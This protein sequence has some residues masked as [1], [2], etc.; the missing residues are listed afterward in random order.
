MTI[1]A[2]AAAA[3]LLSVTGCSGSGP[4][5]AAA[6]VDSPARTPVTRPDRALS[7][8]EERRYNLNEELQPVHLSNCEFERIGDS[9]D[10]GYVMCRNLVGNAEA[11]Y[12]YGISATDNWGCTLSARH[13]KPVH[14]YD[15]FDLNRPPCDGAMPVFHEECVGGQAATIEGRP[16]DSIEHHLQKNGDAQ[17]R[18]VMKLDVEGSEWES[19]MATPDAVLE[20]VDQ[21]VV[22]FH[23]IDDPRALETIRKLKRTFHLVN[24]HYNNYSCSA[25]AYPLPATVFEGLF[26]NKTVGVV[27][28]GRPGVFPNPLD[29]RN[30][31]ARPDCQTAP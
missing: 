3:I 24:V 19:F 25:D 5:R 15:C 11:F 14:Q 20:K 2:I 6:V 18:L 31:I 10:G 17:K 16:Y 9:N 4:E 13:R 21:L 29:A 26:V 7:P 27:D 1:K 22:E 8:V 23:D 28:A 30:A 12:S